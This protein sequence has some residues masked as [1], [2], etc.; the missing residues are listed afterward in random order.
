MSIPRIE[1]LP[2]AASEAMSSIDAGGLVGR[3]G[4]ANPVSSFESI[5]GGA[6]QEANAAD[7]A[8]NDKVRALATGAIDDLHGTMISV[9][10]AD[11]AIRLVGSV[12]NKILDAFQELWRTSV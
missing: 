3:P 4:E 6:V 8:A 9:K 7:A 10:E 1:P 12:R 5:L 11:I 2:V